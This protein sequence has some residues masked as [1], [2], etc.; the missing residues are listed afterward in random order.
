MEDV[1]ETVE[2]AYSLSM[3]RELGES[4][5]EIRE[6][7]RL[8]Y[9]ILTGVTAGP[10]IGFNRAFLLLLD[11]STGL[12]E[13]KMGVGP[14]STEDA[15]WIWS[16]IEDSPPTLEDLLEE[17]DRL[18]DTSQMPLSDMVDRIRIPMTDR[19]KIPV[20][21]ITR[22]RAF[23]VTDAANDPRVRPEFLSLVGANAFACVP[24]LAKERAIGVILA[25]N[26]YSG[27]PVREEQVE[28]LSIFANHAALAIENVETHRALEDKVAELEEAYRKLE[29]AQGD[30]V[31][32]E[33]LAAMGEMSA[34]VAH[35][36]RNPLTTIG[37][38]ARSILK[39]P[40]PGRVERGVR[41]I[42]EEVERLERILV[43]TMD[44]V[45]PPTPKLARQDVNR[46]LRDT[47]L[48][49]EEGLKTQGVQ[50]VTSLDPELPSVRADADQ[51]KQVFLN[52]LRNAVQAMPN[53][54][55]IQIVTS[56][57]NGVVVVEIE[58]SGEGISPDHLEHLFSPFFTTKTYGTGLGLAV[59][60]RIVED[61]GGQIDAH[62]RVG[63]GTTMRI[64][65]PAYIQEEG[66]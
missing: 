53:G 58:D 43:E 3:L 51:L 4:L 24:L 7:D 49:M 62:S 41:I 1:T 28:F 32:S 40:E 48:P 17:Y 65:L 8:F 59:C 5:D 11:M 21:S 2:K 63:E 23:S 66:R 39:T 15:A 10:A 33:R 45:R 61:H 16:Q 22:R 26:L 20:L 29:R 64:R 37:G 13:G 47:Y 30:L 31:R 55:E 54:G 57:Q 52:I 36:I 25:D 14:A 60:R 6:L 12:L 9:A 50:M 34:R 44:F 27:R 18:P 46:V 19:E 35:E 56:A 42:V 38:F